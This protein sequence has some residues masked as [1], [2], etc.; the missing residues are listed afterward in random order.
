MSVIADDDDVLSGRQLFQVV[1]FQQVLLGNVDCSGNMS[2]L[3]MGCAADVED[4]RGLGIDTVQQVIG[5]NNDR[6]DS[7]RFRPF[8]DQVRFIR[9]FGVKRRLIMR[10]R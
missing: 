10:D 4:E 9:C 5:L 7:N 6:F 1:R 2:G 3:I 8:A